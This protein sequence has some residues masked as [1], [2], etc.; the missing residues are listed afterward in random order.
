MKLVPTHYVDLV[1]GDAWRQR[2]DLGELSRA[3]VLVKN[4]VEV[5]LEAAPDEVSEQVLTYVDRCRTL[6]RELERGSIG[7]WIVVSRPL[8]TH[9]QQAGSRSAKRGDLGEVYAALS[10]CE[11]TLQVLESALGATLE[12]GGITLAGGVVTSIEGTLSRVELRVEGAR[13][14]PEI[15]GGAASPNEIERLFRF[16][17][18]HATW[19]DRQV[20]RL[21]KVEV[22]SIEMLCDPKVLT[23]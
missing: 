4:R 3:G 10:E 7:A 13:D 22:F 16:Y 14:W 1:L 9:V 17:V 12:V 11:E 5:D 21:A 6:A 8:V 18:N 15:L 19:R 20:R 2:E 23:S